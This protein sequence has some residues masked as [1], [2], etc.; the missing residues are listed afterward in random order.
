MSSP[1]AWHPLRQHTAARIA[2]GRAGGSLPTRE[3]LDFRLSHARARDAVLAP[4]DAEE[5][6][7]TLRQLHPEVIALESAAPDRAHFLRRPDAGRR[8]SHPAHERL[9]SHAPAYRGCDLVIVVSDGLSTLATLRQVEPLL[10]ALLPLLFEAGWRLAPLIVVRH[11]RVASQ[12]EIG[13][14]FVARLSLMLLGERPGL[15][16]ADSLGAYFTHSPSPGKTD[17]DRNC[18]SNIRPG[19]IIPAD[20]AQKL[21]A[22]LSESRRLGLSGVGLKDETGALAT[23]AA[24]LIG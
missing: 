10:A 24:P 23:S 15:G 21:F 9:A 19:G 14:I 20:A 3:V 16:N 7:A 17:A 6:A 18:L 2:L 22:L 11:A 12:D 5:F 13:A 8:L 1:D 4:F